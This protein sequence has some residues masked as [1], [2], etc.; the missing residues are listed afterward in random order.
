M[1]PASGPI[2]HANGR[3]WTPHPRPSWTSWRASMQVAVSM[4]APRGIVARQMTDFDALGTH[5]RDELHITEMTAA[6]A[7]TAALRSHSSSSR[8]PRGRC[9]S[10]SNPR[11]PSCFSQRSAGR[12]QRRAVHRP[13]GRSPASSSGERL[14]WHRQ[15]SSARSSAPRSDCRGNSDRIPQALRVAQIRISGPT[16]VRPASGDRSLID[17]A[18]HKDHA[19]ARETLVFLPAPL[20]SPVGPLGP[21]SGVCVGACDVRNGDRSTRDER[22]MRRNDGDRHVAG[23]C[24]LR[25]ADARLHRQDGLRAPGD[26]RLAV[27]AAGRGCSHA[28]SARSASCPAPGWPD[29]RSRARSTTFSRL[30]CTMPPARSGAHCLLFQPRNST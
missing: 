8:S 24:A 29:I 20:R 27:N 6:R 14:P 30:N 23:W 5:A 18:F 11:D 19:S 26:D 1:D 9:S 28:G 10:A 3:R 2:S 16:S 15:R 21:G 7:V 12:A 13:R 25:R 4:P 22:R 17:A